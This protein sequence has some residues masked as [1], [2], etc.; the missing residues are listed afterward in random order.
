MI[1]NS[2]YKY[3]SECHFTERC[4]DCKIKPVS[5]SD[6]KLH[7]S[8]GIPSTSFHLQLPLE[9][10]VYVLCA[11]CC[12]HILIR[13]STTYVFFVHTYLYISGILRR[14]SRYSVHP[15]NVS[16]QQWQPVVLSCMSLFPC[17]LVSSSAMVFNQSNKP[18]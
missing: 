4:A 15:G 3:A 13:Q 14:P 11:R 9:K 10:Y 16:S 18:H 12:M 7:L 5:E 1:K 2:V 8:P 6:I 17:S